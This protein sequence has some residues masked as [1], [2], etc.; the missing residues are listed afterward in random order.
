[1]TDQIVD[2]DKL[3]KRFSMTVKKHST[4]KEILGCQQCGV[5]SSSCPVRAIDSNYNPRK[6]IK[7]ALLGMKDEVT[8]DPSIW[9]CSTCQLCRERCP[10]GV[11]PVNVL[12]TLKNLAVKEN[13]IPEKIQKLMSEIRKHGGV[14]YPIDEFIGMERDDL[15]LP[16]IKSNPEQMKKILGED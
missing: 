6:I 11:A 5:C 15:G 2:A 3:D 12:I 14:L 16:K 10:Q 7:K 9:L 8:S 13:K 4:G 1:M